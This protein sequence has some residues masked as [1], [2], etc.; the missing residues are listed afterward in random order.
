M[1]TTPVPRGTPQPGAQNA[2]Q[3]PPQETKGAPQADPAVERVVFAAMKIIYDKG[4]M[5]NLLKILR[6][7]D[8]AEGLAQGTLFVMKG[9][10]EASKGTLPPKAFLPA[11]QMVM[12][13][14]AELGEAAGIATADEALVKKAAVLFAQKVKAEAQ[15]AQGAPTAPAAAQEAAPQAASAAPQGLIAQGMEI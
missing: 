7:G 10:F 4:I 9:L 8:P 13:L 2:Q 12:P 6:S 14:I 15:G 3:Q 11:V 1:E 5:Q